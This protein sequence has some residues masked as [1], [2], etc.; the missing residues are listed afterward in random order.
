MSCGH[1]LDKLLVLYLL[2]QPSLGAG[3]SDLY[4]LCTVIT[5]WGGS[6]DGGLS[7]CQSSWFPY[8]QSISVHH[9]GNLPKGSRHDSCTSRFFT[10]F[11]RCANWEYISTYST[12]YRHISVTCILYN[13]HVYVEDEVLGMMYSP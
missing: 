6:G 1:W 3:T 10:D 7:L 5:S 8:W 11:L 9:I 4:H 2:V 12:Y 13:I